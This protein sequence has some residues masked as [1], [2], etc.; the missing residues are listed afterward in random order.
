M[1]KT[2]RTEL[3]RLFLTEGL[4]VPLTRA[5]A[6]IQIFDN[7]IE[8]T[9]IRLRSLRDPE[10]KVWTHILEQ[11]FPANNDNLSCWKVAEMY[12]NEEEHGRFQIFKGAEIR[13]NRYFHELDERTIAFDVFLGDLWGLNLARVEFDDADE[14]ARFEPPRFFI[15]EVT[16]NPFFT[17]ASLVNKKYKDI[18][19]EVAKI[20]SSI[21]FFRDNPEE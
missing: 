14:M 2:N 19:A 11:G 8:G 15:F 1:D 4:P 18:Q 10:T 6:H 7:Y 16:S 9:R 3:R 5:S 12:L 21:P 17:G 13:K 20:D